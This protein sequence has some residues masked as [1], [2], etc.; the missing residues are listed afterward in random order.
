MNQISPGEEAL[1]SLLFPVTKADMTEDQLDAFGAAVTEQSAYMETHP[2]GTA[3]V[4][5]ESVGDVSVSYKQASTPSAAGQPISP[6]AYGLLL[7]AGLL[8]RWL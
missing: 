8:A 1:L 4:S 6:A 2:S 7:R 5:S 3:S